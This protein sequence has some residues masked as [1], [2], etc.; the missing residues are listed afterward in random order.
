M[1]YPYHAPPTLDACHRTPY[2]SSTVQLVIVASSR[3]HCGGDGG[4]GEGGGKGEGGGGGGDEGGGNGGGIGGTQPA[5]PHY[6]KPTLANAAYRSAAPTV[7]IPMATA[8]RLTT[9]RH[10]RGTLHGTLV[11]SSTRNESGEETH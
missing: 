10:P 1:Y 4:G 11:Q 7:R 6:R 3:L 8:Q 2:R 9:L 5:L